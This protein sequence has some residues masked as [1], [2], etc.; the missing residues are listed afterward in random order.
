M[1]ISQLILTSRTVVAAIPF[2]FRWNATW[3]TE[4]TSIHQLFKN[5]HPTLQYIV[6]FISLFNISDD[7]HT[8]II[9]IDICINRGIYIYICVYVYSICVRG[10]CSYPTFSIHF[11]FQTST[12]GAFRSPQ[13]RWRCRCWASSSATST[14]L[15]KP[16]TQAKD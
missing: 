13:R 4:H 6:V 5:S 3:S 11:L 1:N 8:Y 2:S 10:H 7:M 12:R 16:S 14:P 9:C 15:Q